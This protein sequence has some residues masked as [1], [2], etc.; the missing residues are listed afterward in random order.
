MLNISNLH[1]LY[2]VSKH[3]YVFL[4]DLLLQEHQN[5]LIVRRV[6]QIFSIND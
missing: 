4:D 2:F 6:E 5:I 1:L 3:I